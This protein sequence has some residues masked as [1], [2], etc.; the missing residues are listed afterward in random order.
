MFLIDKPTNQH[1][2]DVPDRQTDVCEEFTDAFFNTEIK[3]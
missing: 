3:D 1:D 2:T